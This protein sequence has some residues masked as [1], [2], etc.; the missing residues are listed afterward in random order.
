[1][2]WIAFWQPRNLRVHLVSKKGHKKYS[3]GKK[4]N[5]SVKIL[6]KTN[7]KLMFLYGSLLNFALSFIN[8]FPYV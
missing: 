4:T 5:E 3:Y 8:F 2:T 1:M 7:E 6:I